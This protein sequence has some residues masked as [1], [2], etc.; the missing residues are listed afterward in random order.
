M[1]KVEMI[2]KKFGRLTVIGLSENTSGKRHRLMYYCDC[3]CGNKN[4]EIV[5][6]K[7]R[8][9]HT[10]SCGCLVKEQAHNVHKKY[11]EYDLSGEYGIGITSNTHERFLFDLED[12]EKIRE[13]CWLRDNNGY[14]TAKTNSETMVYLHRLVM[15][16]Q[17]NDIVDHRK[18]NILDN[19]KQYLRIGTQSQNMM[20]VRKRKDNTSG[21][22]GIWYRNKINKWQAE[23]VVNGKKI[24]LGAFENKENAIFARKQAEDEY[25]GEWS[26]DNSMKYD[27]K[28]A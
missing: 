10:R 24:Y 14:I 15:N 27:I 4:V 2:G 3:D 13:Y 22:K 11:N 16:A 21:A 5:G 26:F 17:E 7:L 25:C 19:R 23:I 9:G 28:E 8:S 6:E 12:F 20:N 1:K 18:H